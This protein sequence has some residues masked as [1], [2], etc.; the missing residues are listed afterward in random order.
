METGR[1]V[2]EDVGAPSGW[3][4]PRWGGTPR[5]LSIGPAPTYGPGLRQ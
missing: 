1:G 4:G 5:C 2:W 3:M